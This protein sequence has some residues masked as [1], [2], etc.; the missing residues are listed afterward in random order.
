MTGRS[1]GRYIDDKT[2]TADVKAKLVGDK[3]SAPKKSQ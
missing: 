2:I 3:T 1:A